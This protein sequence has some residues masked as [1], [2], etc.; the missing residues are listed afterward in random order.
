M[1]ARTILKGGSVTFIGL[2]TMALSYLK[3]MNDQTAVTFTVGGFIAAL[4]IPIWIVYLLLAFTK[5][6]LFGKDK[7]K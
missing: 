2:A 7:S 1:K 6:S 5:K 3:G 4:G